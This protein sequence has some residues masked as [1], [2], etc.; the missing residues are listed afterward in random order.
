MKTIALAIANGLVVGYP[1]GSVMPGRKITRAE[2]AVL[3]ERYAEFIG[4]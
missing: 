3:V 2:A 4:F 1:G